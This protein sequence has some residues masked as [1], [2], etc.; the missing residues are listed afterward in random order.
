VNAGTAVPVRPELVLPLAD[1]PFGPTFQGEGPSA[2][3][4]ALFLR[5]GGCNL[6]CSWCDTPYSWDTSRYSL[7]EEIRQ[8]PVADLVAWLTTVTRG[9]QAPVL[10][11]TGGEPLL[12]QNR[13]AF[14]YLLDAVAELEGGAGL[15]LEVETNGTIRPA[16]ELPDRLIHNVSPKLASAGDPPER[17]IVPAALADFAEL[18]S[19]GR[20]RFKFVATGPA[21]LHEVTEIVT[22]HRLPARHVWISPEGTTAERVLTI[23]RELADPVLARGW[24]L[25]LRT[26]TLLWADQRG[27]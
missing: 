25:T 19:A 9:V 7:R 3:R 20:A 10:A 17:R 12:H 8:V 4:L 21:D 2:G 16:A 11:I 5:L 22:E 18:A 1:A 24:N 13:P 27:R 6:R 15:D 26:H 14:R 23:A